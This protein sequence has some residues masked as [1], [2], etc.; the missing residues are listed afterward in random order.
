MTELYLELWPVHG[1]KS[2][3]GMY[4]KFPQKDLDITGRPIKYALCPNSV[5]EQQA[6]ESTIGYFEDGI[7][8][9]NRKHKW[10][11][12]PLLALYLDQKNMDNESLRALCTDENIEVPRYDMPRIV[13]ASNINLANIVLTEHD[14]DTYLE[15]MKTEPKYETWIMDKLLEPVLLQDQTGTSE[16][17]IFNEAMER[18]HTKV[19]GE[20]LEKYFMNRYVK[21][22]KNLMNLTVLSTDSKSKLYGSVITK[23]QLAFNTIMGDEKYIRNIDGI[24]MIIEEIKQQ[25]KDSRIVIGP[26]LSGLLYQIENVIEDYGRFKRKPFD[27]V[28]EDLDSRTNTIKI[29]HI[30]FFE[31]L[32]KL[33]LG[34]ILN[35]IKKSAGKVEDENGKLSEFR[36]S[37]EEIKQS[38]Q[39][40]VD[41][42]KPIQLAKA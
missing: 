22:S 2:K 19:F 3:S 28:E 42:Y 8:Y 1:E 25:K 41:A 16:K 20:Y 9:V 11:L 18:Y 10:T 32:E 15:L 26:K 37:N 24:C 31:S 33:C 36:F 29:N 23:S 7:A 40:V 27:F 30:D 34:Y 39:L 35:I 17:V 6:D 12:I 4:R 21:K 38:F 13:M 14:M 5:I